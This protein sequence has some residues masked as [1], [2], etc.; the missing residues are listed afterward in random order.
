MAY[1]PMQGFQIGQAIGKA[2][3]SSLGRTASYMSDLTAQRDKEQTKTNPFEV[4][5]FKNTLRQG[6]LEDRFAHNMEMMEE[7]NTGITQREIEKKTKMG[8]APDQAGRLQSSLEGIRASRHMKKLLFPDGTPESFQRQTAFKKNIFG[9]PTVMDESARDLF[10]RAGQ[11]IAGKLL[12]QS[13]VQTRAEEYERLGKQHVA[14]AFSNPRE[15]KKALD[16]LETFYRGFVGN[17][18]PSG[19]FHRPEEMEYDYS[20]VG[21][22]YADNQSQQPGQSSFTR[23]GNDEQ[24]FDNYVDS[25][26]SSGMDEMTAVEK[27]KR[28]FGY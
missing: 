16:E 3:K 13:G 7:R 23:T 22:D 24:D 17:V 6:E 5:A 18:D 4:L 15:A 19:L 28:E 11:A 8:L 26:I 20:D 14:D 21:G 27:A 25:L 10:R 9:G 2:K 12:V 1:D